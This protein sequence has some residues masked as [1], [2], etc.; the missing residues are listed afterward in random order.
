MINPVKSQ[1]PIKD[2]NGVVILVIDYDISV[3]L[4]SQI[5]VMQQDLIGDG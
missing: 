2:Y 1:V 5:Q 3:S 4:A